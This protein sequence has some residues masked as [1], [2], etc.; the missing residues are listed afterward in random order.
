MALTDVSITS[1]AVADIDKGTIV[2]VIE[3]Q[4]RRVRIISPVNGWISVTEA[5]G[6]VII[7]EV[8]VKKVYSICYDRHLRN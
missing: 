5:D 7:D 6:T 4:G 2:E 8:L 1:P 3:M